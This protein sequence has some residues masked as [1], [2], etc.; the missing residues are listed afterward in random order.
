MKQRFLILFASLACMPF[1]AY[2][3]VQVTNV[4]SSQTGGVSASSGQVVSTSDSSASSEIITIIK[5]GSGGG[6]ADIRITTESNG[7]V[8]TETQRRDFAP[9]EPIIVNVATSSV[10]RG[11]VATSSSQSVRALIKSIVRGD[12]PSVATSSSTTI[13]RLSSSWFKRW[14][15]YEE[16]TAT[17]STSSPREGAFFGFHGLFKAIFALFS[18]F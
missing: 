7:V 9:G 6:S 12:A 1:F 11:V 3:S 4:S 13:E 2:A 8:Q 16:T 15:F 10:S 17:S 18:G 14:I 5:G